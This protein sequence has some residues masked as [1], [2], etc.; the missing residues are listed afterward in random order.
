MKITDIFKKNNQTFS[1]EFFPPKTEEGM[2]NLL[3]TIRDLKEFE[4]DFV[5]VTYGAM[6]TT[7]DKTISIIDKIQNKLNITA[8]SHLTC[9]GATSGQIGAIL[10]RLEELSIKNIMALRGDPPQ[11]HKEFVY[12]PGGFRNAT[13]LIKAIKHK[14]SFCVGAAGY[15]EGHIEAKSL[16]TDLDYLKMKMDMGADFI[17]TQ[18][19]L[20]N[21]F[22]YDFRERAQ[23][24]GVKL[25]LIPGIMPVTNF[26]QI[27]KF[28][29]MCGCKIPRALEAKLYPIREDKEEVTRL[30]I[31]YA[32]AQ[33]R[34]L[35]ANEAP[36][37]H[38]YTLNKS[39]ATTQIFNSLI[40]ANVITTSPSSANSYEDGAETSE[41]SGSSLS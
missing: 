37:L 38:F 27:H 8:M 31:E 34:D 36:G 28:A 30:G 40:S 1:F 41:S 24:K 35:L 6:G 14:H 15:P 7:Q 21:S 26:Q 33:C 16:E 2:A 32:I 4:P 19:F 23:K 10:K 20:D 29:S 39:T 13:D 11:G 3:R 18:L 9:V 25:R 22:Y 12:T 5:S 17:V